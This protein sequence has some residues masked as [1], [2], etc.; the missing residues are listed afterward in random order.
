MLGIR[1]L[2]ADI[3]LL[4]RAKDFSPVRFVFEFEEN[5]VI[6]TLR[7]NSDL[8]C[9][10]IG[11]LLKSAQID[12]L[13]DTAQLHFLGEKKSARHRVADSTYLYHSRRHEMSQK[14]PLE[15]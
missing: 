6:P 1:R 3:V 15:L 8:R 11:F 4:H 14:C 5:F 10:I 12:S 7:N 13:Q 9:H 2:E